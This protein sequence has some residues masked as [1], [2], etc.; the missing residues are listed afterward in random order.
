MLRELT[1]QLAQEEIP[2]A[3]KQ[4]F[5][6]LLVRVDAAFLAEK[7]AAEEGTGRT[8][9]CM[10]LSTEHVEQHGFSAHLGG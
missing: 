10:S 9:F 7:R 3:P 4:G 1:Q 5:H 6:W 2:G 8:E